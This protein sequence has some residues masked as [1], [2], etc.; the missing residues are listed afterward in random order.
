MKQL[1]LFLLASLL[2]I[3]GAS[4]QSSNIP[5]KQENKS[6]GGP[7]TVVQL[8]A[9]TIDGQ[10]LTISFADD[11]DFCITVTDASG[12]VVYVSTYTARE[13]AI[14]LPL[15]PEG[16]YYLRIEDEYY[17]YIGEFEIAD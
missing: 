2:Y 15:L 8:P 13:A 14:T 12:A 16:S 3:G 6:V 7:R 10:V 9:A 5:L 4:A 1:F 17:T 11:A